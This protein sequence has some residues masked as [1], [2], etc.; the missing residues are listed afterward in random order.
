[1]P[2]LPDV[3]VYLDCL[4]PRVVGQVL[5]RV[6]VANPF[7]VRTYDPPLSDCHGKPVR[8]LRRLGKR[9]VFALD[10]DLF[11]VLHLMIAGR[12]HWKPPG[13]KLPGRIGLAAFDFPDGTLTLTEAGSKKRASLHLVRGGDALKQ[14]D[15][16][17][18]DVLAADLKA[19]TATLTR[20]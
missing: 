11:L 1:M 7:L 9:L 6:R 18:L 5:D 13:A 15:P 19:F 8:G 2:E 20:E 12:L 10:D 16:G 4:R 14:H 17:G 3:A